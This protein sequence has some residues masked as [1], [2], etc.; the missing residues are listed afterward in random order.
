MTDPAK[1]VVRI[2]D[3]ERI[4]DNLFRGQNEERKY[5]RLFGGQVLA[6]AL[7]AAYRTI[8]T[9]RPCHSLHGYFLRP[10][11]TERP[12]LYEVGAIR[13]GRSFTTRSIKA[14][15]NGE[16]IF[17]M[18]A[19][20]QI[21]EPGM[22]HQADLIDHL[23]GPAALED[24]YEAGLRKWGKKAMANRK[25]P[26]E[27]RTVAKVGYNKGASWLRFR[28]D[29]ANMSETEHQLLLSYASDMS[30]ISTAMIPHEFP[31]D[32]RPKMQ[33]ASLDHAIW[34]HQSFSVGQWLLYLRDTPSAAGARGFTRGEF[35]TEEGTLV[36]S[37]MQEGLV[38][39]R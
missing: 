26:F 9:D 6:Q 35:Y 27:V 15:Q 4:E 2:L 25:R 39:I 10:G 24:D 37:V 30:L 34:F 23:P 16:A 33:I 38:R 32:E 19:S 3:L 18:D 7:A 36:A 11:D 28:G 13:D 14:I 5:S 31:K 1:D 20:F 21:K 8:A 12:V 17:S 22:S 29:T